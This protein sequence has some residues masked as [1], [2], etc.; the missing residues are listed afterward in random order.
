MSPW[1][2]RGRTRIF[3]QRINACSGLT[4]Q[5]DVNRMRTEGGRY[6]TA[7]SR[8][9]GGTQ[10][11]NAGQETIQ[12]LGCLPRDAG[13]EGDLYSDRTSARCCA[14]AGQSSAPARLRDKRPG[15]GDRGPGMRLNVDADKQGL[16]SWTGRKLGQAA[17]RKAESEPDLHARLATLAWNTEEARLAESD[18]E[19]TRVGKG[20]HTAAHNQRGIK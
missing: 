11:A 12:D 1:P 8:R 10:P 19:A 9:I 17:E 14:P 18:Q 2:T 6:R 16:G 5:P 3:R 15:S 20:R 7:E 4:K 13:Q